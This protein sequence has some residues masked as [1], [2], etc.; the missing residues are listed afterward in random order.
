MRT[1]QEMAHCTDLSLQINV[2]TIGPF[3]QVTPA[4]TKPKFV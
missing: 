2:Q 1:Y 4:K 3:F